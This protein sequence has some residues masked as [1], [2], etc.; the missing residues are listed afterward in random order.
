MAK[1]KVNRVDAARGRRQVG[2]FGPVD[3]T[4]RAVPFD[5]MLLD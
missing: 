4:A 5:V 3:E 2:R 1:L